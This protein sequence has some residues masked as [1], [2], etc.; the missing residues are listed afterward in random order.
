[1]YV[2]VCIVVYVS[3]RTEG[4]HRPSKCVPHPIQT[5]NS[6]VSWKL[7]FRKCDFTFWITKFI[8]FYKLAT[9]ILTLVIG[10]ITK[11]KFVLR[12]WICKSVNLILKCSCL[13]VIR[14][15]LYY[16]TLIMKFYKWRTY[17][18]FFLKCE[19]C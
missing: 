8:Q 7:S 6:F 19:N 5:Q 4:T 15:T 13:K 10:N 9:V 14:L 17:S 1:M 12:F 18:L 11:D 2:C 16:I 3:V